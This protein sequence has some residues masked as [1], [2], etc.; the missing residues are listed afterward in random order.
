MGLEHILWSFM[1]FLPIICDLT[2][3]VTDLN[4]CHYTI[5]KHCTCSLSKGREAKK[6]CEI[7]G[8]SFGH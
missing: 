2:L 8:V 3:N 1:V 7:D 5:L 6:K 4:V